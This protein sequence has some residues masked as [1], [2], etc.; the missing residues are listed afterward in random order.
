LLLLL[1]LRVHLLLLLLLLLHLSRRNR[2]RLRIGIGLHGSRTSR[3]I[4][5]EGGRRRASLLLRRLLHD[6]LLHRNLLRMHDAR[7]TR[8]S[9]D[10]SN[11][12]S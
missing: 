12:R 7:L 9:C 3:S 2:V 1:N 4:E 11:S 10:A 8:H 6:G 5:V